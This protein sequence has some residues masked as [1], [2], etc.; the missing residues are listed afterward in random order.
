MCSSYSGGRFSRRRAGRASQRCPIARQLLRL[1]LV[2]WTWI[3]NAAQD[4]AIHQV[5]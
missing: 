1:P 2:R 3:V 4:A 5:A